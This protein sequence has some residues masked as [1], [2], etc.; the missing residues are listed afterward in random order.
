MVATET[1]NNIRKG[2]TVKTRIL[3]SLSVL[4]LFACGGSSE[5]TIANNFPTESDLEALTKSPV[6]AELEVK[7]SDPFETW[8]LEG[9]FPA[10][11]G[12]KERSPTNPLE[13]A[14]AD[15]TAKAP[16]GLMTAAMH[17]V[18]RE[19]GRFRMSTGSF[20]FDS[21]DRFILSRCG[22]APTSVGISFKTWR[23][24][25]SVEELASQTDALDYVR[26]KLAKYTEKRSNPSVGV[27]VGHSESGGTTL[28]LAY[29]SRKVELKPVP[30]AATDESIV[31]TGEVLDEDVDFVYAASTL[32]D[33]GYEQCEIDSRV[34][35]P[36]FR[37]TCRVDP[38]DSHAYIS[39]TG[40]RKGVSFSSLFGIAMAWAGAAPDSTY[41]SP[42][43]R[44][45]IRANKEKLAKYEKSDDVEP[46]P[47][48]SDGGDVDVQEYA[49]AALQ[50]VNAVRN[51]AGL[52]PMVLDAAQS[53]ENSRMTP[54]LLE[55]LQNNDDAT[56]EK[57]ILGASAGWKAQGNIVDAAVLSTTVAGT[58]P[59][60]LL[61]SQLET[62]RGRRVYLK[63]E[64]G[65]IALGVVAISG[66][67][68]VLTSSYDFMPESN[69]KARW[70]ALLDDLN[71]QRRQRG[72]PDAKISKK[73]IATARRV[74]AEMEQGE[75]T[76]DSASDQVV[77]QVYLKYK[78]PT[79]GWQMYRNRLEDIDWPDE[80][81]NA[82]S[83]RVSIAV[84]PVQPDGYPWTAYAIALAF[85]ER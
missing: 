44:R 21:L 75:T 79:R 24:K 30:M 36:N 9:P 65:S 22:A 33:F 53:D 61:E 67:V 50:V 32:G 70:E 48:V 8:E 84:A 52:A 80:V 51:K 37:M 4:F 26:A 72:L 31:I 81:V 58:D 14:A 55:A 12:V 56:I 77:E 62:A 42:A 25:V 7:D 69:F 13:R 59:S 64:A 17:C 23:R 34:S 39:L 6:E 57:I 16:G 3:F 28:M 20:P 68:G 49:L 47:L 85:P 19:A 40:S 1:T 83:M 66:G 35:L 18:A 46:S 43:I 2:W 82:Q 74:S 45:A 63:P 29:G 27:W 54:Y 60:R 41:R 38:S 15:T 71:R 5:F 10:T 11:H 78:E 76:L 73:A